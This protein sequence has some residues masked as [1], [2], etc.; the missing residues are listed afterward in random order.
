M[1]T[2]PASVAEAKITANPEG[3]ATSQ[4]FELEFWKNRWPY[5]HLPLN[6]LQNL[7]HADA[8]WLLRNV[9][10]APLNE[11]EFE[12]FAGNVLE[13]G[14]GPIGFFELTQGVKAT[15]IDSLMGAYAREISYSTL[16]ERG[17]ATYLD[18]G[19]QEIQSTFDFVVCSNVL[20][21]TADWME[22][23]EELVKRVGPEGQLILMTDTRGKPML[24]H[25]QVFSPDQLRRSLRWLGLAAEHHFRV[26]PSKNDHCDFKVFSRSGRAT[27]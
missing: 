3:W 5:R 14:C 10:F 9:G 24:G 2:P 21:H 23:L 18:K 1:N 22:F 17:N 27:A 20:D 19:L 7:R 8:K 16:G 25:T 26:E 13:V 6:E 15:A 12:G 4:N 11:Y